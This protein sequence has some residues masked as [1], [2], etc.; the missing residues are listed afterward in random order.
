MK[1]NQCS[2]ESNIKPCRPINL[3]GMLLV[4]QGTNTVN[5]RT[6]TFTNQKVYSPGVVLTS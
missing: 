4:S 1:N 6:N 3:S 5:L 2:E